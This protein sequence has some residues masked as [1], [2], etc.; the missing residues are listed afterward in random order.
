MAQSKERVRRNKAFGEVVRARRLKA[1]L[2]QETLAL[3]CD[4][5]RTF[6]SLLERGV[7]QPS[8]E[9]IFR[10]AERLGVRPQRLVAAVEERLGTKKA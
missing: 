5:H 8:L 7:R 1:G 6:I 2:S 10:L 3:E 4:L 9:T